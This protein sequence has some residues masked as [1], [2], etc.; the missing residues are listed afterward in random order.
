MGGA[1]QGNQGVAFGARRQIITPSPE[2]PN[3]AEKEKRMREEA[4]KKRLEAQEYERQQ[5]AQ[6]AA[7]EEQARLDEERR[8]TEETRRLKEQEEQE[9]RVQERFRLEE[10]ERVRLEEQRRQERAYDRDREREAADQADREAQ[11]ARERNRQRTTSDARLNGQF[12]S[13]YRADQ[14]Q[15]DAASSPA[16]SLVEQ[17]STESRRIADLERQLEELKAQ[18][19]GIAQTQP[20]ADTT[21][22]PEGPALPN[23][24]QRGETSHEDDWAESERDYLKQEW[25]KAQKYG[26]QFPPK[27]PRPEASPS[28]SSSRPLPNPTAYVPGTNRTDRY[29]AAYSPPPQPQVTSYRP[30]DFS[31]TTEVDLE[32][33][34]RIES[35]ARTKAGGWASKSL[36]EREKERERERQREW[37]DEQKA[38]A[39][40]QRDSN[41]GIGPG[42]S[43]DVHQYGYIGGDNQN[44]GG[45]GLGVGGARRQIIGPRPPP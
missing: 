26:D 31:T 41:E 21:Y 6:R 14:F 28:T 36:L 37:E 4:E 2:V 25:Q 40:R 18:Q 45:H 19:R 16:K 44:R 32:R 34:R 9:Q 22:E 12:L 42:Q 23:R 13:Q 11:F 1:S 10:E 5:Q 20:A 7:E 17:H 35:Q 33:E 43:W 39:A 3:L 29:L 38:T 8:W 27:P 24:S 30:Q 15:A